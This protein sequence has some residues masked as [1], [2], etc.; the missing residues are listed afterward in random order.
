MFPWGHAAVGYLIYRLIHRF[1]GAPWPPTDAQ[2]IA[3]LFGTQFPDLVDKPLAW[4]L[5]LLPSGRSLAHSLFT[6]TLIVV[7]VL[8]I[9]RR[10]RRD[11]AGWA[12][13]VGYYSHLLG[14]SL[15]P[16]V[17]FDLSFLSF[18]LWPLQ[19]AP[20]YPDATVFAERLVT[21]N[22]QSFTVLSLGL[23][24]ITVWLW[25]RDGHPGLRWMQRDPPGKPRNS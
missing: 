20:P 14:D 19:P 8:V 10:E 3:L 11:S 18:L 24:I 7:V 21:I 22:L 15:L 25:I 4:G 1:R 6:T 16:L 5:G 17:Q 9:A 13:A 23:T 2:A 12:F